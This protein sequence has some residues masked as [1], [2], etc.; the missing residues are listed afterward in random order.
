[1]R[2]VVFPSNGFSI[3]P[4][5]AAVMATTVAASAAGTYYAPKIKKAAKS[6][7]QRAKDLV[8]DGFDAAFVAPKEPKKYTVTPFVHLRKKD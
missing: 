8:E 1:M 5:A 3:T 7:W 4:K 2:I 6:F